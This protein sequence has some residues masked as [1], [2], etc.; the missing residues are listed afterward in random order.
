MAVTRERALRVH[1]ALYADV[2]D[3]YYEGS[4]TLKE[5]LETSVYRLDDE[6]RAIRRRRL[7]HQARVWSKEQ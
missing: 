2:R 1:N 3:K 6:I 4:V 7:E 5:A